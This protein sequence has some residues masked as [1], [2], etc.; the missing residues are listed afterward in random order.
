VQGPV[1]LC[2]YTNR[3][4]SEADSVSEKSYLHEWDGPLISMTPEIGSALES[5]SVACCAGPPENVTVPAHLDAVPGT[6]ASA[7]PR[8]MVGT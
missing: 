4:S 3:P 7:A 8:R 1:V 2:A 5:D 6:M